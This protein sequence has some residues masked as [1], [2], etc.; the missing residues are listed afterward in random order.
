[1]S[2][3]GEKQYIHKISLINPVYIAPT[4]NIA[5]GLIA[6]SG[7]YSIVNDIIKHQLQILINEI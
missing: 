7:Y 3:R 4:Y 5:I 2:R 1:M 6:K